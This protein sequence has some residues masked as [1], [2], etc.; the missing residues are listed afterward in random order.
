MEFRFSGYAQLTP[1]DTM[2]LQVSGYAQLTTQ[3]QWNFDPQV[4]HC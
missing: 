3:T 2:E 4:V 1:T